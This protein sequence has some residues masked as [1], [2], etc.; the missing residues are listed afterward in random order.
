MNPF[1]IL[2][3]NKKSKKQLRK[4]KNEKLQQQQ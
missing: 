1:Q 4:E 2:Q 3:K